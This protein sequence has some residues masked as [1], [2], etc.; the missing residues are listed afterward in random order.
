MPTEISIQLATLDV[1]DSCRNAAG[2]V[3]RSACLSLDVRTLLRQL[4]DDDWR[5]ARS[6]TRPG[7]RAP[8]SR[9]HREAVAHLTLTALDL[10]RLL[11]LARPFQLLG[12]FRSEKANAMKRK[13]GVRNAECGAETL[14]SSIPHSALRVPHSSPRRTPRV[15]NPNLGAAAVKI[16]GVAPDWSQTVRLERWRL[17]ENLA[18]HFIICPR[19]GSRRFK[20]YLPLCTPDEVRDAHFAFMF[21]QHSDPNKPLTE[22]QHQ[23]VRRYAHLFP[24][25]SIGCADC[26]KMR[27]GY[28]HPKKDHG[29]ELAAPEE[30]ADPALVLLALP[31]AERRAALLDHIAELKRRRGVHQRTKRI[32]RAYELIEQYKATAGDDLAFLNLARKILR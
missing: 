4:P 25:R 26:L 22:H 6:P 1:P 11:A 30:A 3:D 5:P 10:D 16:A 2:R 18:R 15:S 13:C 21:L 32:R 9:T 28:I 24:P 27:F 8:G 23:L 7:T 19:C 17:H 31:P 14:S 20:L 29:R 12:D